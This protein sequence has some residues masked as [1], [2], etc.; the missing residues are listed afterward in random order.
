MNMDVDLYAVCVWASVELGGFTI[1]MK[2]S[3][4]ISWLAFELLLL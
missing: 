3:F 1:V 2:L 4:V